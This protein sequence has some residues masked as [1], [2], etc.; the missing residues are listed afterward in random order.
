MS[1]YLISVFVGLL[2]STVE[3]YFL[4]ELPNN[5]KGR[6]DVSKAF[7]YF[8]YQDKIYF[9]RYVSVI[10]LF[11]FPFFLRYFQSFSHPNRFLFLLSLLRQILPRKFLLL[12][13]CLFLVCLVHLSINKWHRVE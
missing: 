7:S 13:L 2:D 5:G 6:R 10:I 1:E 9:G 11:I 4:I 8:V 3:S 12:S